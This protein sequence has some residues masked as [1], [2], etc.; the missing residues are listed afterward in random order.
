MSLDTPFNDA[1]FSGTSFSVGFIAGF[2]DSAVGGGGLIT[3]PYLTLLLTFPA[4]AVGTNKIVGL[5]GALMSFLVYQRKNK[6]PLMSQ[7]IPFAIIVAVGSLCG[8][9]LTPIV[10]PKVFSTLILALCPLILFM[11]LNRSFF[12][13]LRGHAQSPRSYDA[14][15]LTIF[16]CVAF[17]CGAY[18]GAFGPGGGTFMFLALFV[19]VKLPL[20]TALTLS[21]LANTFSAG[22]SLVSFAQRGFVHVPEGLGIA[23]GMIVGSVLGSRAT[24]RYDLKIIRPLL[25]IVVLL[26]MWTLIRRL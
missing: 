17:L 20:L 19:V 26:L 16:F 9:F 25:L 6:V 12:E 11:V 13:K 21:K 14:R 15:K 22:I 18:D 1:M 8:S 4:H 5:S 3:L 7:G 24:S 2:I 23:S 10:P